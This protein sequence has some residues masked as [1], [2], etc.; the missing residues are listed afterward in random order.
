MFQHVTKSP[1]GTRKFQSVALSG[2]RIDMGLQYQKKIQVC[3]NPDETFKLMSNLL[4]FSMEGSLPL[5]LVVY[6]LRR[7]PLVSGVL[8]RPLI[9]LLDN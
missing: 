8:Q 3:S 4:S 5:D 1:F 2:L 9:S 6:L 7:S